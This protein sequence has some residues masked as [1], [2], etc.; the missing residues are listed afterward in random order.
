MCFSDAVLGACGCKELQQGPPCSWKASAI[1]KSKKNASEH[2]QSGSF[3]PAAGPQASGGLDLCW[4]GTPNTFPCSF[5]LGDGAE[6]GA[7]A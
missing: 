2:T 6:A 4:A 3:L 7:F 1:G 5:Q